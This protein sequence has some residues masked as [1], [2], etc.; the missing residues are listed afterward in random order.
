MVVAVLGATAGSG[1]AASVRADGIPD[2]ARK[3]E[4][5]RQLDAANE[6]Q[7]AM[8][9]K[10]DKSMDPG[11]PIVAPG[12]GAAAWDQ[13]VFQTQE[14]PIPDG[15]ITVRSLWSQTVGEVHYAVYVGASAPDPSRG[16]VVVQT[17]A[18]SGAHLDD[19]D[20]PAPVGLGSLWIVS[21]SDH[22]LNLAS[23]SGATI[24]FDVD[25]RTFG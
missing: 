20:Y 9:P 25:T 22:R 21:A 15:I 13:G 19:E 5:A 8:A 4:V 2:G 3:T 18:V 14:A 23:E 11:A 7:R 12:D 24:V 17:Y 10:G 1:V 16:L 6:A